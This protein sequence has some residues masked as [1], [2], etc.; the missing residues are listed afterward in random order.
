VLGQIYAR[1]PATTLEPATALSQMSHPIK[2]STNALGNNKEESG[3]SESR[4]LE[5]DLQ[6]QRHISIARTDYRRER[7][8]WL[9]D[10]E[11]ERER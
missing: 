5:Q 11:R 7:V 1:E 10:R 6:K 8:W 3:G 4:G 2:M 9:Q